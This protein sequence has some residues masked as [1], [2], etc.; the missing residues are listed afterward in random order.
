MINKAISLLDGPD[1]LLLT[2]RQIA[3]LEG[4]DE[5]TIARRRQDG[6]G[7]PFIK[8]GRAVRYRLADWRQFIN[9]RRVTSTTEADRLSKSH[10]T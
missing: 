4:L 8:I 5:K 2:E 9:E 3:E 1:D 10:A 7:C 6:G